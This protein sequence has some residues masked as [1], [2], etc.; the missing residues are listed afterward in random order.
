MPITG[1]DRMPGAGLARGTL[2]DKELNVTEID[3]PN[4]TVRSSLTLEKSGDNA[5]NIIWDSPSGDD[6]DLNIPTMAVNDTFVFLALT[7]T[8][9]NKTLTSPAIN[10]ATVVGGTITA[11][12]DL[13]MAVGNRTIFDTIA[14][15]T[16][17]IGANSTTISIP[18]NLTISGTTTTVNTTTLNVADNL[19]LM[20]SDFTG[21]ATEDSGLVIERGDDTNVAFVWDESADEFIMVTTNNAGSGNNITEIAYANLQ[22]ANLAVA[23]IDAFTLS[24]KL[25]A[26]SVEIEGS[27]FDINGGDLSI[28]TVSGGLT[29]SA[30]QNLN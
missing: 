10:S 12:T 28:I 23:Q 22:I 11:I 13:D 1:M 27:N 9:T 26:G 5:Y 18:G 21:S 6:R 14:A 25:T 2:F 30:A 24:G 15:N 3:V 7:Q 4:L 19:F 17:T 20:N 16:L 29:W 8:L